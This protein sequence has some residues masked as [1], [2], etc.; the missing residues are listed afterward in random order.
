MACFLSFVATV[1]LIA[2]QAVSWERLATVGAVYFGAGI[3]A[4]LIVGLFRPMTRYALGAM[5]T[6]IP[7]FGIVLI[8]VLIVRFGTPTEW[9]LRIWKGVLVLA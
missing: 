5:L 6:G 3:S 7:A 9:D 8:S 1:I 4:G 2:R